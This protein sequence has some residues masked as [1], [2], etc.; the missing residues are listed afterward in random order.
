M[1][2][3]MMRLFPFKLLHHDDKQDMEPQLWLLESLP[4]ELWQKVMQRLEWKD[5]I[6]LMKV[7]SNITARYIH[8]PMHIIQQ[9]TCA[10]H[11]LQIVRPITDDDIDTLLQFK[12]IHS[13]MGNINIH[14]MNHLKKSTH[15]TCLRQVDTPNQ[16]GVT[17][18]LTEAIMNRPLLKKSM[19]NISL[20]DFSG[21]HALTRLSVYVT[22]SN[23][24]DETIRSLPA[25]LTDLTLKKR[26][27]IIETPSFEPFAISSYA[28]NQLQLKTFELHHWLLTDF[29]LP[30][31][32]TRFSF[33]GRITR[34]TTLILSPQLESLEIMNDQ[35]ANN[36]MVHIEVLPATLTEIIMMLVTLTDTSFSTHQLSLLRRLKIIDCFDVPDLWKRHFAQHTFDE[37]LES[38]SLN[39]LKPL[40][41]SISIRCPKLVKSLKLR[42]CLVD[43]LPSTLERIQ[44]TDSTWS[45]LID[46]YIHTHPSHLTHLTIHISIDEAILST[47]SKMTRL[48][49]FQCSNLDR[50]TLTSV[51]QHLP[52]TLH[53]LSLEPPSHAPRETLLYTLC[54]S[55]AMLAHYPN[56]HHLK[57]GKIDIELAATIPDISHVEAVLNVNQEKLQPDMHPFMEW[58][59]VHHGSSYR[60]IAFK[61]RDGL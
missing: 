39:I 6:M 5:I 53:T 42:H 14:V 43:R 25:S 50:T 46:N 36:A 3:W 40:L 8:T 54:T 19:M 10:S 58:Q 11:A 49:Y 35:F 57:L 56:I 61:Y 34:D 38:L 27:D 32:V 18:R 1:F 28:W 48:V 44:W 60:A 7:S 51:I 37:H 29:T 12:K 17:G 16:I 41:P 2:R 31:T 9:P 55:L 23:I 21:M 26:L 45:D 30:D 33:L 4:M 15:L 20:T 52:P 13:Y 47:I 22:P 59:R 24:C